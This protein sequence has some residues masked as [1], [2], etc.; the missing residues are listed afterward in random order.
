M[1]E[2]QDQDQDK[3]VATGTKEKKPRKIT[4]SA[5]WRPESALLDDQTSIL[6]LL[7]QGQE[8]RQ[9]GTKKEIELLH[10]ALHAKHQGYKQQDLSKG[11]F[12]PD[13]WISFERLLALLSSS[14]LVCFYCQRRTKIVYT[15]RCDPQQWTLERIDNKLG[16]N[17]GNVVIACLSCNVRRR[18]MYHERYRFT[19]QLVVVKKGSL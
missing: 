14:Q 3:I 16:H 19:K 13:Q 7:L 11:L 8:E 10:Q 9:Q 5:H 6:S 18:T 12:A 4:A 1:D 15:S 2:D 17:D